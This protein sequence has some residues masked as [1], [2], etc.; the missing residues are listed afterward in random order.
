MFIG[1]YVIKG[2]ILSLCTF[3]FPLK[4]FHIFN[5]LQILLVFTITIVI[6]LEGY[7]KV[8]VITIIEVNNGRMYG[9]LRIK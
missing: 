6:L 8:Q 3:Y 1:L 2:N 9:F 4:H 5:F 7:T